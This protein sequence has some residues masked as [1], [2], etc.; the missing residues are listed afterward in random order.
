MPGENLDITI[1]SP[2]GQEVVVTDRSVMQNLQEAGMNPVGISADGNTIEF[3]D[4]EGQFEVDTI[5]VLRSYGYNVIGIKPAMPNENTVDLGLRAAVTKLPDDDAKQAY[6]ESKLRKAGFDEPRV[7]GQGRDWHFYNP[8]D[9]EW[10]A[11]TNR[12]DWDISDLVEVGMQAPAVLGGVAGGALG[13][14]TGAGVGAIPGAALGGGVGESLTRSAVAALDPE[15]ADATTFQ[16][17][18]GEVA[19]EVGLGLA[20]MGVLKGAGKLGSAAMGKAM[21]LAKAPIPRGPISS[22]LTGV[23]MTGQAAGAVARKGFGTL[24]KPLPTDVAQ[25]MVPGVGQV[26]EAGFL[27]E[28]PKYATRGLPKAMNWVSQKTGLSKLGNIAEELATSRGIQRPLYERVGKT[29]AQEAD[30]PFEASSREIMGNIME[31]MGAPLGRMQRERIIKGID[32]DLLQKYLSREL[33]EEQLSALN[34]ELSRAVGAPMEMG[35]RF[36]RMGEKAGEF[37]EQLGR[38]GEATTRA[39]RGITRGLFR[40][41]EGMGRAA[42]E[43]GR[44][45]RAAGSIGGPLESYGL[46]REALRTGGDALRNRYKEPELPPYLRQKQQPNYLKW[47]YE[48]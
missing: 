47:A 27:A 31:R 33:S 39:T 18:A 21:P 23:G 26:A 45:L 42:E 13:G 20:T 16:E 38:V 40:A 32:D 15:F 35:A 37:V 11:L 4:P 17:Q 46:T 44:G 25:F 3:A 30:E 14:V 41:G 5:D 43:T 2:D 19:K 1:Q 29:L 10:Q 9:G 12:Q 22:A 24:A 34:R 48:P 8:H 6:I 28:L 36:G 7:I